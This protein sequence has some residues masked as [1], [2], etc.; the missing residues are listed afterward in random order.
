[1][2]IP[3]FFTCARIFIAPFLFQ[4]ISHHAWNQALLLFFVGSITDYLD[5]FFAR[6]L[7]QESS[8]GAALDPIADK[9]F[10]ITA[11]YALSLQVS[12]IPYEVVVAMIAKELVL[13]FGA[14]VVL[15]SIPGFTIK[16]LWHAKVITACQCAAFFIMIFAQMQLV[17]IWQ[18][19]LVLS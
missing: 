6:Y 8:F 14:L 19:V 9:I 3:M 17:S 1:M 4:A 5:G 18:S 11:L 2:M 16:P 13:I 10:L 15:Y 12:Y 7:Q